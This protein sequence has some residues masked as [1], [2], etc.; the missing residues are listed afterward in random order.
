MHSKGTVPSVFVLFLT[1]APVCDAAELRLYA[2]PRATTPGRAG[3]PSPNAEKTDG[4]FATLERARDE[5]RKLKQAGGLPE[6]GVTVGSRGGVYERDQAVRAVAPRIRALRA[7]RS[8]TAAQP[9]RAGPAGRRQGGDGLAAGD[10]S[11]R[12]SSAW[13]RRRAA[14]CCR[15]TCK[16]LGITDFGAAER[17]RAGAVL[18]GPAR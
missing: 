6:G 2:P 11:R 13:T 3:W 15:P 1:A 17:R 4:P 5:I 7:R 18:P 16:A 8:C 12:C 14:R 10:R 9:G